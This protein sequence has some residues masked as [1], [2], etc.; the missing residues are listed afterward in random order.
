MRRNE[1]VSSNAK[2]NTPWSNVTSDVR[3]PLKT[4]VAAIGAA[5]RPRRP[6]NA[7][8]GHR[9]TVPYFSLLLLIDG[10]GRPLPKYDVDGI[11]QA[12]PVTPGKGILKLGNGE[13]LLNMEKTVCG[14]NQV[15]DM[16]ATAQDLA[17][18]V[19][20]GADIGSLTALHLYRHQR[21]LPLQKL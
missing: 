11:E 7:I 13:R 20:Q 3:R 1:R 4:P 6:V 19:S 16:G 2:R 21:R 8:Q 17:Q 12:L 15:C 5:A 18:I 10:D 9:A 14:A